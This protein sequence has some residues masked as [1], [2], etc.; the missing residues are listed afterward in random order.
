MELELKNKSMELYEQALDTT[1]VL[2]ENLDIIVPDLSPDILRIIS[3]TGAAYVKEKNPRD[4]KLDV[5][6]V[7]KGCALFVAEG[8]KVI[9]RLEFTMPFAHVFEGY[10]VTSSSKVM[11]CARL[12]TV[13]AR[14]I[15]PRKINVRA[16][17][18]LQAAA[19]ESRELILCEDI[20][21]AE[22]YGIEIKKSNVSMYSP[23]AVQNKSFT[24]SDD[25]EMPSSR[26]PFASL[27]KY[28]I[29]LRENDTK[30][31]GN[32]AIVK[33]SA[34]IKYLYNT[35][36]GKIAT[37]EHE[38][39][40][41]QIID[42]EGI[43]EECELRIKYCLRGA[44][45]EPQHDMSGDTRYIMVSILIDACAVAYYKGELPVIC[46]VYST[47]YDLNMKSDSRKVT[48]LV[49]NISKRVAVTDTMETGSA[50][51]RVVDISIT[52]EPFTKRREEG[53]AVLVNE[54][55]ITVLYLGDDD[56][57]YCATR[58]CSVVCPVNIEED[59]DYICEAVVSGESYTA[60]MGNELI[61]RFFTDYDI[62]VIRDENVAGA[63]CIELD[64]ETLKDVSKSPS[65]IIKYISA[66]QP[67]WDLAKHYN[68]TVNE[69]SV[70]NSLE[71]AENIP[72]GS[73][74]L[75]PKKR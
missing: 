70:A 13:D 23:I 38:L 50:I 41:S 42:I 63:S 57:P 55:N 15:N 75:I 36:D 61:I 25:L 16:V 39:P 18:E 9:R 60:G 48:S 14:E 29:S 22:D 46:D 64:E 33:G 4:G 74:I 43:N 52:L 59:G 40:F 58:K 47:K 19:F 35:R 7:I 68:T 10:G 72:A 69:I 71:D 2:E 62:A 12:Q 6:G 20:E 65:V 49:D 31:I 37:C 1:M 45:I 44:D 3:A 27:L 24:I 53:G 73:L 34:I 8:D 17:I 30:I 28:D 51:N 26:P 66:T 32:K 21:N 67:L 56:A 54:A 11:V 5:S